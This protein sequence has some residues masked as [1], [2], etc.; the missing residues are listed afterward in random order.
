M[1]INALKAH[2]RLTSSE[3]DVPCECGEYFS[4]ARH[5]LGYRNCLVCGEKNAK[6]VIHTIVPVPKSNYVYAANAADVLSPYAHKGN[7]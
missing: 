6:A 3:D 2:Q 4:L 1:R 7:R 5:R